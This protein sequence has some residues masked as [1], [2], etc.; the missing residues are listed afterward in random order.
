[1]QADKFK[2]SPSGKCLTRARV[3]ASSIKYFAVAVAVMCAV[4]S[5]L[6]A[7]TETSVTELRIHILD[8]SNQPVRSAEVILRAQKRVE[9]SVRSDSTGRAAFDGIEPGLWSMTV[10]RLGLSPVSVDIRIGTGWNEYTVV[11]KTAAMSLV[12]VRIVGGKEVSR[13][14]DG[15]ERRRSAGSASG[16]VTREQIDKLGPIV[17]SRML[18]GI[19]GVRVAD[20][21]G[22]TV[23]ISTR[24]DKPTRNAR[25]PGLTMVP[26]VMRVAVDGI[27]MPAQF[28]IDQIVPR[29][30]HGIE[31][32]SGPARTPPELGGG[33][34]TDDWC[35]LIAI[36][37]RDR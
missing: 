1:M 29:D 27:L 13:R 19:N 11:T 12:G 8:E 30:V 10:R 36:W 6:H 20:S 37:T 26:C 25:G 32:F 7:Q 18:R 24:G 31:V 23:A 4:S 21:S 22:A 2:G 28:N 34:R 33:L 14:L 15:F 3:S 17:L 5:V 16:V 35:G 9:R